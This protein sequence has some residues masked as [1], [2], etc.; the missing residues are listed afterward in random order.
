MKR[1]QVSSPFKVDAPM[2]LSNSSHWLEYT[3]VSPVDQSPRLVH[4][5]RH[6][7]LQV[8]RASTDSFTARGHAKVTTVS[9]LHGS[10]TP[11]S[12]FSSVIL[13]PILVSNIVGGRGARRSVSPDSEVSITANFPP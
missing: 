8:G 13:V 7:R 4:A 10:P 6:R 2:V 11:P 5:F 9:L 3:E 12:T 1:I